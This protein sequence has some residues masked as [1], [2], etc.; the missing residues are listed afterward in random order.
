MLVATMKEGRTIVDLASELERQADAKRDFLVH[1]K[2]MTMLVEEGLTP[3]ESTFKM[4]VGSDLLYSMKDL[5][6]AQIVDSVPPAVACTHAIA[7]G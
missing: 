4:A 5:A 3:A 2:A 6:H 7:G 1:D